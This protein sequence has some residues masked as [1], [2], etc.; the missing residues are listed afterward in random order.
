MLLVV[1]GMFA[2][3]AMAALAIDVMTLYAAHTDAQR[4]ADSA[5]LAG[6]RMF[7]LSGYTSWQLGDPTLAATQ[8]EACTSGTPGSGVA[9]T[10]ASGAGSQNQIAGQTA[11]VT[12]VNCNFTTPE[13]PRLTVTT[14]RTD[15]PTFFGRIFGSRMVRVSARSTAEAF[16]AS[17]T[18]VPISVGSVKPWLIPNCDPGSAP[19]GGGACVDYFVNT[20]SSYS[21]N[22]PSSYVGH[23]YTFHQRFTKGPVAATQYYAVDMTKAAMGVATVCPATSAT[24]CINIGGGLGS[25]GYL[26]GIACAN[27]NRLQCGDS[28]TPDQQGGNGPMLSDNDSGGECLIHTAAAGPGSDQDSF[29]GGGPGNPVIIGG[30]L[31]NPN[32]ALQGKTNISRSDSVVTVPLFSWPATGDPCNL[33]GGKCNAVT[34]MGF[35]QLGIEDVGNPNPGDVHAIVLNAAGCNPAPT[36]TPVT[37]GAVSALPVRLVN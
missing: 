15:L 31:S 17:G 14:G 30:G 3:L 22:S 36:A 1:F 35:L 7:V 20:A 8:T 5:A 6:A 19:P 34:V 11:V 29:S 26:D 33:P 25:V 10:Q 2:I 27:T 12:S 21:L 28:V 37:G 16:N 4:V 18:T 13:N 9:D 32:P 23:E 24:G